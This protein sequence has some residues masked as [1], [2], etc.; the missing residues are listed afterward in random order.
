MEKPKVGLV[1][2]LV[3]HHESEVSQSVLGRKGKHF[4]KSSEPEGTS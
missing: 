4:I 2:G 3:A 1:G